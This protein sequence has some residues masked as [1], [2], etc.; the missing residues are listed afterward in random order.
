[1]EQ[2][3]HRDAVPMYKVKSTVRY[4]PSENLTLTHDQVKGTYM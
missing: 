4:A 2:V 3:Y 1:M